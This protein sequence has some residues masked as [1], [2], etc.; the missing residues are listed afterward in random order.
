MTNNRSSLPLVVG[1]T[2]Y[3]RS[4]K[5]TIAKYI[6]DHYKR[7]VKYAF[8]DPV[9]QAAMAFFG[10]DLEYMEK[11]KEEIDEF[12]GVSPRQALQFI[13]TE[14][15]RVGFAQQYPQFQKTTG[16]DIWIKRLQKFVNSKP[17]D[18]NFVVSDMRFHNEFDHIMFSDNYRAFTIGVTRPGTGGDL[19]ASEQEIPDLI[20]RCDYQIDNCQSLTELYREIN[21][22]MHSEGIY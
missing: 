5:D 4:G 10:W 11:H 1:I 7:F 13:G 9:R 22:A 20:E 2:G 19:H 18:T 8:A 16:N 6:I 3:K 21:N 14:V 15:G 12:W 17:S